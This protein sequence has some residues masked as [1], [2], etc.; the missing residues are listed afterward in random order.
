MQIF[1]PGTT[2]T[3]LTF[4]YD[5]SRDRVSARVSDRSDPVTHTTFND[6]TIK[7]SLSWIRPAITSLPITPRTAGDLSHDTIF[8]TQEG[9]EIPG[10]GAN[11]MTNIIKYG[12]YVAVPGGILDYFGVSDD[13]PG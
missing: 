1:A 7:N 2:M 10:N 12:G 11:T 6:V 3:G 5:V 9:I 8:T 4:N 13:L